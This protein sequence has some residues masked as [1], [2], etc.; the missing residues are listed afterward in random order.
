MVML[1]V[2]DTQDLQ[3][4]FGVWFS[5]NFDHESEERTL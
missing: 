2:F 5:M 3:F 4:N 1:R